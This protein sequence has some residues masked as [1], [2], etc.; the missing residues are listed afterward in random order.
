MPT[1][2]T[3]ED[4]PSGLQTLLLR[5]VPEN[6]FGNKTLTHL[7]ATLNISRWSITKWIRKGKI[8]PERAMQ[9]VEISE[10]RVKIEDFH[11]YVYKT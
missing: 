9:I 8:P 3:P 2:A 10:G 7:A 6:D 4:A 1:Y 5:A 11:P